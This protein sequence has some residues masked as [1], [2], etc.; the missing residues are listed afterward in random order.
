M[1]IKGTDKV[2]IVD[3]S[4]D[5]TPRKSALANKT[6]RAV[7]VFDATFS[8]PFAKGFNLTIPAIDA[9]AVKVLSLD[10]GEVGNPT[11]ALAVLFLTN[12]TIDEIENFRRAAGAGFS[13]QRRDIVQAFNRP[14]VSVPLSNKYTA[15]GFPIDNALRI[16]EDYTEARVGVENRTSYD[17]SGTLYPNGFSYADYGVG[18]VAG[19]YTYFGS[20]KGVFQTDKKIVLQSAW[21]EQN[22]KSTTAKISL[23]NVD[24]SA[25]TPIDWNLGLYL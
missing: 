15:E 23:I 8:L 24:A 11:S 16:T 12:M 17:V 25:N 4:A 10:M 9:G 1:E 14:E 2:F 5:T 13:P 6:E 22:G 19:W 7:T 20:I 18:S 21:L 3:Q